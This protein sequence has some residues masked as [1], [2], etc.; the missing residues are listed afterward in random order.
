[1]AT[2]SWAENLHDLRMTNA[3]QRDVD[4]HWMVVGAGPAGIVT[5]GLLL[6]LGV[7]SDKIYWI[8]P[9]FKVGRLGNYY[10][11]VPGN[12]PTRLFIDFICSC[13]TFLNS[14]S[15]H[16]EALRQYEQQAYYELKIIIDPLQDIT[17][18][19]RTQVISMEGAL[20]QLDFHDEVW[21]AQ[22][23]NQVISAHHVVLATGSHPRS[24]HYE[25][26][27]QELSLDI[28]LQKHLLAQ[29]VGK[30]ETV[31]VIGSAHSAVLLLKFLYELQI[32]RI[33][34]FYMKP[35][36]YAVDMGNWVL[37]GNSG[38]KGSTAEWAKN[39][40][41]KNTPA[42]IERVLNTPENIKQLLPECSKIIYA[43]GYERNTLPFI[44][45]NPELTYDDTTGIIAPRLFG[46]G[47][48]F[49]EKY[50][51]PLGNQEHRIGLNSFMTYA[52]RVIPQ[53]LALAESKR[54]E[55]HHQQ[56]ALL[57]VYEQLFMIDLL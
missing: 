43:V 46:I 41:E 30:N 27:A 56:R 34:N 18:Y 26:N 21:H 22:V 37:H 49:P 1:M 54:C 40:L 39:V 38:L 10:S 47:I 9:E 32:K 31:A 20:Q 14:Q 7:Q 42:S 4:A 17:D 48:A 44:K 8:D 36:V 57:N 33:I 23:N 55:I 12:T 2:Y 25:T 29:Q 53:W 51:D 15:P 16:I 5:V 50:T 45:E 6:D 52:Q 3:L 35:L 24:L 13:K 11:T 28:A 19:I